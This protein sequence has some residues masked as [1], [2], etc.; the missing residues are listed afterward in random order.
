MGKYF[1][2]GNDGFQ[3]A[4]NS[5][6]IDKSELI[7]FVN[8]SLNTEHNMLC[9]TRARRFGK[10]M[11]AKM[12]CAYYDR[13]CDSRR[14]F[15]DL[16]ISGDSTFEQHL[17]RYPVIYLDLT[18]FTTTCRN[19]ADIVQ[20]M[21]QA[22][23]ADLQ[24]TYPHV[25]VS[26][27]EPLID[28]LLRVSERTKQKFIMIVDEWDTICRETDSC[29]ETM[30]QYVDWLRSMFKSGFTDRVFAGVYMTGILPI[31][32]YDTQSALNNFMEFSM[33]SP[34]PLAEYFGFT[35][36]QVRMLCDK[37]HFNAG[38]LKL[39]YDGYKI[40]DKEGV[41]NP[42]SVMTAIRQ[43]SLESYWAT[44]GAYESLK[45]YI[46]LNYDGLKDAVLA[47]MSGESSP[48]D[49]LRFTN[50]V[51]RVQSCDDA[52]T[53]LVHLGYLSY[54]RDSMT[55]RIP[56]FEVKREFEKSVRDTDWTEVIETLKLSEQ[57]LQQTLDGDAQQVARSIETAHERYTGVIKYNDEN[58]LGV[59]L[60]LAHYT[61][62]NQYEFIREFPAGK[63]Y[64]DIVLIP[65]PGVDKP[66]VVLE[67]KWNKSAD[68]AMR[69][70]RQRN[71]A[72]PLANFSGEVVL[73]G[74]NYDKRTKVHTCDIEKITKLSQV[75]PKFVPSL[76]QV[77][78]GQFHQ[79]ITEIGRERLLG[80][81][82]MME[83]PVGIDTLMLQAGQTN[84][85]RFRNKVVNPLLQQQ[86]I[87]MT[88]PDRP[89]SPKQ[90]YCLTDKGKD[91]LDHY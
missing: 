2:I 36:S 52:L 56:N 78:A 68:T 73:V 80:I 28:G 18:Y 19:R 82:Q 49:V 16:K 34:G 53:T 71:Y 89:T 69:Q 39:W 65:R 29:S 76:S 3:K 20:S 57:L 91:L 63:G 48:V 74:I 6:Y 43:N 5:E 8:R 77:D 83:V 37:Y 70:I 40:G 42:Y 4:R 61:A 22:L 72:G 50:N 60:T 30:R 21:E 14:L 38:D 9:V 88:H 47:M 31:I 85:S 44:T 86:Y 87:V 26:K 66:A 24:N 51:N 75:C 13:S 32:Q 35:D 79:V 23:I 62:Q 46:Q 45:K 15:T 58:S 33:V 54:D 67:L 12:L 59:V 90:Q 25:P 55:C 81:L 10:S 1:D 17:N 64:A 27:D 41:Y 7:G 11:A 84:R